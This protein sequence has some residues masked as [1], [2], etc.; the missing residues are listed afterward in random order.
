MRCVIAEPSP[1]MR[2]ILRNTLHRFGCEDTLEVS[3]GQKA[4][5]GCD[6]NTSLLITSWSVEGIDEIELAKR[7]RANPETAGIPMLMVTVR[8][9]KDDIIQAREAGISEYMLKPFLAEQLRAKIERL[10]SASPHLPQ[11]NRSP[12]MPMHS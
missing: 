11:A 4:L 3:D 8:N 7:L 5:D 6:A 10:L 1:S 9:S 2:R 12:R